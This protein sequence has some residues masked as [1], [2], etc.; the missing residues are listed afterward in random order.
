VRTG[1]PERPGNDA[2]VG[3]GALPA[4]ADFAELLSGAVV[5][6]PADAALPP[7]PAEHEN[8]FAFVA[9]ELI[10]RLQKPMKVKEFAASIG[11]VQSQAD[12]WLNRLLAEGHVTKTKSTYRAAKRSGDHPTLF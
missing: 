8:L 6:E 7:V 3:Q 11:L 12:A 1:N 9:P 5:P 4:P 10:R 2:L